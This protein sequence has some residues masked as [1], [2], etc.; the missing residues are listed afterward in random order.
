M[1]L[2][3]FLIKIK[4][5]KVNYQNLKFKMPSKRAVWN[6]RRKAAKKAKEQKPRKAWICKSLTSNL[7]GWISSAMTSGLAE[8]NFPSSMIPLNMLTGLSSKLLIGF[9]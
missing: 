3:F 9:F 8:R 6:K 2:D 7:T 5:I 1:I 4:Q